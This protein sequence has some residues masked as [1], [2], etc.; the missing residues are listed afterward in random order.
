MLASKDLTAAEQAQTLTLLAMHGDDDLIDQ[1]KAG[2]DL[3]QTPENEGELLLTAGLAAKRPELVRDALFTNLNRMRQTLDALGKGTRER[4]RESLRPAALYNQIVAAWPVLGEQDRSTAVNLYGMLIEETDYIDPLRCSY[5]FL[6]SLTGRANEIPFDAVAQYIGSDFWSFIQ[7]HV[8][9]IIDGWIGQQPAAERPAAVRR[10]L[11]SRPDKDRAAMLT[12]LS[13]YLSAGTLTEE[14]NKEFPELAAGRE[15][16]DAPAVTSDEAS[17]MMAGKRAEFQQTIAEARQ[18]MGSDVCLV[19]TLHELTLREA[20]NMLPP[21]E[22]DILLKDLRN[23]RDPFEKLIAFLLLIHAGRDGEAMAQLQVIAALK[24]EDP[25]NEAV[26]AA[27]P[28]ILNTYGWHTRALHFLPEGYAASGGNLEMFFKLHDPL[29]ILEGKDADRLG[30]SKRR[31]HAA[32]LMAS[33][34]QY[35][36][37]TRIYFADARHPDL[38]KNFSL[39]YSTRTWPSR[40]ATAPGGL[41][42][43]KELA[44]GTILD[45]IG[46]LSGGQD[47]LS[48]WLQAIETQRDHDD[49]ICAAIAGSVSKHGLSPQLRQDWQAAAGRSLL[50]RM[51]IDLI[52]AIAVRSPE[53]LPKELA[54][55]MESFILNDRRRNSERTMALA[56]ACKAFGQADLARSLGR[57]SVTMDL[58][59]TG[60][61]SRLPTYLASFPEAER[62]RILLDL[63]P[64]MGPSSLR[65]MTGDGLGP[66]LSALLDHG[67]AA[68]AATIVDHYL[69]FRPFRPN[70]F[71]LDSAAYKAMIGGWGAD[72]NAQDDVVATALARLKRPDDYERLLRS[73]ARETRPNIAPQYRSTNL[74]ATNPINHTDTLPEPGDVDDINRYIDIHLNVGLH[75]R[76]EGG[77]SPVNQVAWICM[78]GEWCAKRGLI[79]RASALLKQAEELSVGMFTGRLWVADLHRLMGNKDAAERIE[80]EL[81]N[82]DLL[83]LPRVLAAL[84]VLAATKGRAQADAVAFRVAGYSN[85]PQVLPQA[86]RHARAKDLKKESDEIAERLRKV[87]TLFLP[88]GAPKPPDD[89]T[90][91]DI[92]PP[93][94]LALLAED[95]LE[96][97]ARIEINGENP[98]LIYIPITHDN[99]EHANAAGGTDEIE[100]A[101]LRGQLISEHLFANYGIRK[102]LLEGL[103]KSLADQYNSPEF[104]KRKMSPGTSKS[105]TFKIWT[106]LLNN[107]RWQ[108]VPAYEKDMFGPLT[109]LGAEYTTRIQNALNEASIRA[110]YKLVK[111]FRQNKLNS[112][113]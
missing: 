64:H 18:K 94:A 6:L 84:E 46:D 35:L 81:L 101:L 25:V 93:K 24:S 89:E 49:D 39:W 106:E 65:V 85:H 45:D 50:N 111:R 98:Q 21:K 77:L 11:G 66:M 80:Q 34:G 107:N 72:T 99:P 33:P 9:T 82:L 59:A 16:E 17:R 91:V 68:E 7:H 67:M 63:L 42:G 15:R 96:E 78:L 32:K 105:V 51:D 54:E 76:S 86:L 113:P 73:K 60:S 31:I 87:S 62:A 61:S 48:H 112:R 5:H 88:P 69:R 47:E 110:G 83:P 70:S 44:S 23:S 74:G 10:L 52:S 75:L 29:A 57:W 26:Q 30:A 8:S 12:K 36:Q 4:S 13:G 108:L 58:L 53:P 103:P 109:L 56:D 2:C 28:M 3:N 92:R 97:V 95:N 38:V 1:V 71:L 37:A 102:I 40:V 55:Q 79:D 100:S 14:L 19:L 41:I 27:M 104:K 20:A 22:L 43:L 90:P